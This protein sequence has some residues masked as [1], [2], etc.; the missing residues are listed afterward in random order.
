MGHSRGTIQRPFA[1]VP[2]YYAL[3]PYYT[4]TNTVLYM[5]PSVVGTGGCGPT[6]R[7]GVEWP[8]SP[9][10]TVENPHVPR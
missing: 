4:R 6:P 8:Q 10:V 9:V 7:Y 1:T 5:H 2:P 3:T